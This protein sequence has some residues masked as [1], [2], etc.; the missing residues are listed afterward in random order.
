LSSSS[1]ASRAA[2]VVVEVMGELHKR[3]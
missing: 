1:L 2:A 3:Q